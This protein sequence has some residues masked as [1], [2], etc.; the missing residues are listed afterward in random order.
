MKFKSTFSKFI[1]SK[2]LLYIVFTLSVIVF[3]GNLLT[4]HFDV[5]VYYVLI[6]GLTSFFTNNM[7]IVL[8]IPLVSVLLYSRFSNH[9][10]YKN[11][12]GM[13]NS[14]KSDQDKIDELK[15]NTNSN[16]ISSSNNS[17]PVIPI[18]E[19]QPA[20]EETFKNN[21]S[22]KSD[23]N[24]K[25]KYNIDYASTV[26]EAYDNL[27]N[28]IGSDGIQNL[29][30]D[31]KRLMDQQLKLTEAM[32]NI[33]PLVETMGPLLEKAGGLLNSMGGS[34]SIGNLANFAKNFSSSSNK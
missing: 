15:K 18:N 8:L 32:K 11:K 19:E 17:L 6:A 3:L 28:I 7:T 27:N 13:E 4:G 14:N 34:E 9:K 12:E 10:M 25:K 23:S 2:L 29:T 5:V 16:P 21:E 33:Q 1:H 20:N 30:G 22:K 31:T 26:E 24:K